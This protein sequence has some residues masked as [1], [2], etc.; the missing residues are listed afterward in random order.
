MRRATAVIWALMGCAA[1]VPAAA[2]SPGDLDSSFSEDGWLRTLEVRSPGNNYLPRA[3]ED[4]TVQSDG[5]I[6]AVGELIDG[7]SN[8]YFGAFR[9]LPNGELD[10]SFGEG[11]W[12]DTDFGS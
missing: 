9:Y 1:F 11:G 6:V 10:P 8:W 2:G 5:K 12:V 3:A 4:V 7:S